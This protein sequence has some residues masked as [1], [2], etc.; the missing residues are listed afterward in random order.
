MGVLYGFYGGEGERISDDWERRG[1]TGS[2]VS[3]RADDRYLYPL[4]LH[5]FYKDL[6][7][8][9]HAPSLWRENKGEENYSHKGG[10]EGVWV[11]F[12]GDTLRDGVL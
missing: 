4:P 11:L 8:G 3:L 1:F 6:C 5:G 2:G 7:K 10:E 9:F 12:S